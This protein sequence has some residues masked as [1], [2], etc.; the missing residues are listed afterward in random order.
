MGCETDDTPHHKHWAVKA[1]ESRHGI[2][3]QRSEKR[4]DQ[5]PGAEYNTEH[6]PGCN[7][8]DE[9]EC[10]SEIPELCT[11]PAPCRKDHF[12]V[13]LQQIARHCVAVSRLEKESQEILRPLWR[14]RAGCSRLWHYA[15][16]LSG[17][18][19]PCQMVS[20]AALESFRARTPAFSM[21]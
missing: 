3:G 7:A 8:I 13:L 5:I 2:F 16:P 4:I 6:E 9:T 21:E 18:G 12:P 15:F 14:V 20:T 10:L 17:Q 11:E 19:R 1:E